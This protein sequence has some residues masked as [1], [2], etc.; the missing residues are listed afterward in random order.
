MERGDRCNDSVPTAGAGWPAGPDRRT[1]AAM[2][3]LNANYARSFNR[4]HGRRGHLFAARFGSR[5]V[6][7]QA[8][9]LGVAAYIA[10]NPLDIPGCAH[11]ADW[12][13]SSYGDTIAGRSNP[14]A[15]LT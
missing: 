4:R 11:P 10:N 9:L 6:Q 2:Q 8:D 13:W 14:L 7:S 12:P 5:L 1:V 15:D 3:R